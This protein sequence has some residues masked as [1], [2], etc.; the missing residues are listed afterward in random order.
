MFKK[1]ASNAQ[2]KEEE[3]LSQQKPL[4]FRALRS[5]VYTTFFAVGGLFIMFYALQHK[6]LYHPVREH[7][8]TPNRYYLQ[9][10]EVYFPNATGQKLHGWFFPNPRATYTLLLCHG[11]AG[12]IADRLSLVQFFLQVPLQIFLFDYQGYGKSEGSP[13]EEGTYR[14]VEAAWKVLL[15]TLHIPRERILVMGRSMGG[16]IASYLAAQQQPTA[17][18][19]E[20]TFSSFRDVGKHHFPLLPSFLARFRY[21]TS[22]Y[23]QAYRGPLLSLH[24]PHDQVVPFYLGEK[25]FREAKMPDKH[26]VRLNGGH[27]DNYLRSEQIYLGAV[28][29]LIQRLSPP[30]S[31]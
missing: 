17:L 27:N 12:N 24:S 16:P 4:W 5:L 1:D 30:T 18:L 10:Q 25:I 26:F 11:N 7:H 31:R 8:A 19:L 15:E 14:D 13:S 22:Q 29:A 6:L 20:S 3:R 2:Q 9:H 23:V 21:P 28:R